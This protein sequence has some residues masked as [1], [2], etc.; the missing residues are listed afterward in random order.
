MFTEFRQLIGTPHY[1]SPEQAERTGV[2]ID[3][4]SDIY[5]LG[6]LLY[7]LLTGATPIDPK[8]L[9]SAAWGSAADDR[10]GRE[11]SRPSAKFSSTIETQ[12]D[13]ARHRRVEPCQLTSFL[14]GDLDWIVLKSLE[15][16]RSRR[17]ATA[18]QF[19]EDI[20][21]YLND[22]PVLATPPGKRDPVR[23]F[24]KRHRRAVV[25]ASL[26]IASVLIG[27]VATTITTFWA[28]EQRADAI[29]A[30]QAA[31]QRTLQVRRLASLAGSPLLPK[32]AADELASAWSKNIE[33]M[34]PAV[35][36]D[37]PDLVRLECQYTT[38]LAHHAMRYDDG[39]SSKKAL[40]AI[41]TVLPRAKR[42]AGF[43]RRHVLSL[44]NASIQLSISASGQG[45]AEIAHAV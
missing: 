1:M 41:G 23:K 22:E 25:F 13:I 16:D 33:E 35:P 4:R 31:E 42:G 38:W 19:A 28:L 14:R 12:A 29:G 5:S 43:G 37:D 34:R 39:D 15:K 26:L 10:R 18:S 6:V 20:E 9:E 27:L 3:T 40:I 44:L 32:A 8:R 24:L 36:A 21:R 45:S 7:E 2:D 17:Y 30:R 11:P